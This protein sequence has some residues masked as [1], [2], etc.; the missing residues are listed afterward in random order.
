M[1]CIGSKNMG[2]YALS[3]NRHRAVRRL[4]VSRDFHFSWSWNQPFQNSIVKKTV[5]DTVVPSSIQE[6]CN[7]EDSFSKR[8][9]KHPGQR[10]AVAVV[11]H[12]LRPQRATYIGC[13]TQV[14]LVEL[15]VSNLRVCRLVCTTQ[16]CPV[17]QSATRGRYPLCC[18]VQY[19][20][21]TWPSKIPIYAR[22]N[23]FYVLVFLFRI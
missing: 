4:V 23:V 11:N 17:P 18:T 7:H 14:T 3:K 19:L 5:V 21:S 15:F 22:V 20:V 10:T 16:S 8:R 12:I 2:R 6:R 9:N 1:S 13:I